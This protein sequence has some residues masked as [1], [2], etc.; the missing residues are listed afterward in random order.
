MNVTNRNGDLPN[1]T[2][3]EFEELILAHANREELIAI[4]DRHAGVMEL[5]DG[6]ILRFRHTIW[7]ETPT[8][9]PLH[10]WS[11]ELVTLKQKT[12]R[13]LRKIHTWNAWLYLYEDHQSSHYKRDPSHTWSY[14]VWR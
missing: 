5:P 6:R 11:V 4:P 3:R 12:P 10:E 13:S 2:K 1:P 8:Q 9:P 7:T 14:K